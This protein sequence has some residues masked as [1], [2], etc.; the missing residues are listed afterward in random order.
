MHILLL[1]DLEN[2]LG[3]LQVTL[4]STFPSFLE[5]SEKDS[6]RTKAVCSVWCDLFELCGMIFPCLKMI[7]R[8][9]CFVSSNSER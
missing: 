3:Y 9:L 6:L 8:T 7:R 5:V 1:K 4:S 2:A